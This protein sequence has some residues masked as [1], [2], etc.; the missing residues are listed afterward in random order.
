MYGRERRYVLSEKITQDASKRLKTS[1]QEVTRWS[2][3]LCHS[4]SPSL[5]LNICILYLPLSLSLSLS[6]LISLSPSLSL[7]LSLSLSKLFFYLFISLSICIYMYVCAF[8]SLSVTFFLSLSVTF[9]LSLSLS[10]LINSL[11]F[12]TK[13]NSFCWYDVYGPIEYLLQHIY[14]TTWLS[15]LFIRLKRELSEEQSVRV[16]L[17]RD[18]ALLKEDSL[19]LRESERSLRGARAATLGVRLCLPS[20]SALHRLSSSLSLSL[21]PPPSFLSFLLPA[22]LYFLPFFI[23][24]PLFPAISSFPYYIS[25]HSIFLD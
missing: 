12:P 5:N 20:S 22:F 18:L 2:S 17:Q 23:F 19:G 24:C 21:F 1:Y 7:F 16:G 13:L 11:N 25:C 4:R 3:S 14:A 15:F 10:L 6:L 9:S 8:L